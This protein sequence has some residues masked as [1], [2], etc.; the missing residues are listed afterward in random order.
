M[1]EFN[2][3]NN[4]RI[5]DP[6]IKNLLQN[7][8]PHLKKGV[9]IVASCC[10]HGKYPMTIV[11]NTFPTPNNFYKNVRGRYMDLV[12]GETI[13]RVKRFYKKD[14][15]GIYFILETIKKKVAP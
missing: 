6:C 13:S 10:G 5:I 14:K 8:K 12:S 2:P 4:S 1:C 3:K 15:Q 11:V 7:L 9:K